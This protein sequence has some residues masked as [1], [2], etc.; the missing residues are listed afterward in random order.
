[1]ATLLT[2]QPSQA[3]MD[4]VN[5]GTRRTRQ[6]VAGLLGRD[7]NQF[8]TNQERAQDQLQGL[9]RSNQDFETLG[10]LRN[11][12]NLAVQ[13]A[14][15]G[16]RSA[17]A[18]EL[19]PR[20]RAAQTKETEKRAQEAKVASRISNLAA[21]PN[22]NQNQAT[23]IVAGDLN[24]SDVVQD[25]GNRYINVGGGLVFNKTDG[26]FL[27]NNTS[28]FDPK[29]IETKEI[30][31]PTGNK[32]A[33][34][35]VTTSEGIKYIGE[36][37]KLTTDENKARKLPLGTTVPLAVNVKELTETQKSI[38]TFNQE[39]GQLSSLIDQYTA[40]AESLTSGLTSN[41]QEFFKRVT[42]AQ[43]RISELRIKLKGV[44]TRA[45]VGKEKFY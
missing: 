22:I 5:L 13:A 42:G 29:N 6:G 1:M 24:Y 40:E 2:G 10:S 25:E 35:I 30:V 17:L 32:S 8:L 7:P 41:V 38:P 27:S 3:A 44:I 19:I 34:A 20:I 45:S 14:P 39:I 43:D 4:L 33:I 21:D 23:A 26:T 36:D 9:L 12:Y 16:K 31:S 37:G 28:G 15:E 18:L 11:L